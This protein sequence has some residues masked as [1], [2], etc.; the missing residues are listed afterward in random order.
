MEASKL[1]LDAV[2]NGM[3]IEDVYLQ[4]FQPIQYEI[5]RL[6]EINQI[7][8]AVEHYTSAATQLIMSQLFPYILCTERKGL[9]MVACSADNELHEI[10]V[11]MVADFFEMYGWDTYYLGANTPLEAVLNT[12]KEQSPHLLAVSVTMRRHLGYVRELID[13]VRQIQENPRLKILIG[14]FPFVCD[15]DLWKE[16]AA[17]G[18][19][20]DARE[21]ITLAEKLVLEDKHA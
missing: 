21:A 15:P 3:K 10:G 9:S 6:W 8:V 2:Q 16:Y 20:Q 11:R 1:I 4:V 5:G 12:L 14:G 13:Q 17:D 7:S 18:C 19:A